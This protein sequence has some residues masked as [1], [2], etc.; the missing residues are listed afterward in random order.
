[1]KKRLWKMCVLLLTVTLVFCGCSPAEPAPPVDE[2][3]DGQTAEAG[4][5][6]AEA[7]ALL[8]EA[9]EKVDELETP[10]RE[11]GEAYGFNQLDGD[12]MVHI[13]YPVGEIEAVNTAIEDWIDAQ[14]EYYETDARDYVRDNLKAEL[15]VE[16]ESRIIDE[17]LVSVRMKGWYEAPFMAHPVD[18]VKTFHGNLENG[19]LVELN[20]LLEDGGLETLRNM[21]A[22]EA[23]VEEELVDDGLLSHWMITSEGLEIILARG[24]YLAMSEG[25]KVLTY[26]YE[27][28]SVILN[29]SKISADGVID[30]AG[31]ADDAED[32][33]PPDLTLPL[34]LIDPVKPMLALTFD[35][36][37]SAHTERLL[38][39]FEE[40]GGKGTFFVV[41]NLIN[42]R[43]ETLVR[44][45]EDGHEIAGHSW[46]HRQL[47]TLGEEDLQKQLVNTRAKIYKVAGVDANLMRPPY[48][49]FN[50]D[51]K[52]MCKDH[53]IA[54]INWSVDTLD[55]KYRDA[56]TVYQSVMNQAKDGAIILCHDL[57]G[58]TVDAMERA[59][60]ALIEEGYQ[61]VTVSQLLT[62]QGGE[63]EAGNVYYNRR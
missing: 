30:E 44:M 50:D 49:S 7:E 52:A 33:T 37:P 36:G 5:M 63:V 14:V 43:K 34:D 3:Q 16:Y 35:D 42:D 53:G 15:T 28:L 25:T 22:E 45:A 46:N 26:T 23:G 54:L 58:S 1:M 48:G 10:V 56:D 24:D 57:H 61:L 60:P 17:K 8:E 32:V 51:V 13:L 12:L 2:S 40:Y 11:Y 6:T 59:I 55:W 29:L 4:G 31:D 9:L 18:I 39:A 27:E 19:S 38:D 47:T 21:V 20:E 41:G 62:S